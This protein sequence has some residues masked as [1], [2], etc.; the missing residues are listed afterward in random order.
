MSEVNT[1]NNEDAKDAENI[2]W[3][4]ANIAMAADHGVRLGQWEA[5]ELLPGQMLDCLAQPI[6]RE[7]VIDEIELFVEDTYLSNMAEDQLEEHER[8]A[9]DKCERACELAE[10]A[11]EERR[12]RE[13]AT[14]KV[15]EC[16]EWL[17]DLRDAVDQQPEAVRR[18]I[19]N[20]VDEFADGAPNY[21]QL[22]E[23]E[24]SE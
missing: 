14:R 19:G 15:R 6:A 21:L 16:R 7:D 9:L 13:Y 23:S 17:Q 4:A 10:D 18:G 3:W 24:Q 11:A 1:T 8:E 22:K 2:G 5:L 20:W 12:I